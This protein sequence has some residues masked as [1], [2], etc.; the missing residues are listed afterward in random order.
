[1]EVIISHKPSH[2]LRGNITTCTLASVHLFVVPMLLCKLPRVP[3]SIHS[4]NTVKLL[5]RAWK[6]RKGTHR[7]MVLSASI[8]EASMCSEQWLPQRSELGDNWLQNNQ[9]ISPSPRLRD[10]HRKGSRKNIWAQRKAGVLWDAVF[11]AR[12]G[13]CSLELLRAIGYLNKTCTGLGSS[14]SHRGRERV[15]LISPIS[16]GVQ[17]VNGCWV[18]KCFL[19]WYSHWWVAHVL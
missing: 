13:S 8:R 15:S 17:A 14:T 19:Q 5:L 6:G 11:C 1:M 4:L 7:S 18:K 9:P 2:A 3:D 10:H 12:H 16:D